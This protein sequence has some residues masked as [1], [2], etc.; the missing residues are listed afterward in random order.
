M[1]FALRG[2]FADRLV[3]LTAF[4]V[5]LLAASLLA[6]IPIYANAVAQ[7]SLRERLQRA[8]V[9]DANLQATVHVF[10]GGGERRL[11]RR[12]QRTVREAFGA[13][14]V[15]IHRSAESE[16]FTVSGKVAVL[17]YFDALPRHAR[18]V[19]GRRPAT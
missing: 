17:G 6:A 2:L 16:P 13:T 12:V 4:L 19:A 3:V 15:A 8:S 18:I 7:S 9:T 11:D 5:V 10:D 14:S 1:T